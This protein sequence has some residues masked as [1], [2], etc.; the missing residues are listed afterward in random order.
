MKM[1]L[2]LSVV[3]FLL[4]AAS[5]Q[6]FAEIVIMDVSRAKAKEMGVAIRPHKNGDAGVMVR[7]EFRTNGALKTSI[8]SS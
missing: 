2:N 7:L 4:V 8:A 6:C 1:I 3:T 5:N